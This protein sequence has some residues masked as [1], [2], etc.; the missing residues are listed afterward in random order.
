MSRFTMI[1]P[2][3]F[4]ILAFAA[5]AQQP[6]PPLAH[7]FGFLE[8][9]IYK[10]DQRVQNCLIADVNGDGLKDVIIVNN[11]KNRLD[12]LQQRKDGKAEQEPPSD[13]NEIMSS[14]RMLHRKI[15]I[16]R[17]VAGLAVRDV[18]GDG[19]PDLIYLSSEPSSVNV[20][21]QDADGNFGDRRSV[22]IDDI[23]A[24][25]WTMDVGDV[26]GDGRPDIVFLSK[27]TMFVVGVNPNGGLGEPKRYKISGADPGLLRVLDVDEDGRQDVAFITQDPQFPVRL[28]L[29]SK[30][31]RLGPEH[32][33]ELERPRSV[34][35]GKIDPSRTGSNMLTVSDLTGRL[36]VHRLSEAKPKPGVPSMRFL[37]FPFE[38][39]GTAPNT[40]L[41]VAD[42]DG[43]GKLDVVVTD[44]GGA[45]VVLY[46]QTEIEGLDLGTPYPTPLGTSVARTIE[47]GGKNR[48]VT[49]SASEKSISLSAWDQNRLSFPRSLPTKDEPVAVEVVGT[50]DKARVV[51]VARVENQATFT[52]KFMLRALKPTVNGDAITWMPANVAGDKS[53]IDLN[54]TTRPADL[55]AVDADGDGND[56]LLVFSDDAPSL[57]LGAANGSFA[58]TPKSAQGSLGNLGPAAVYYGKLDGDKPA[59]LVSQGNFVRKMKYEPE[60]RWR[61]VD[62]FNAPSATAKVAGAGGFDADGDGKVELV[63]YDRSGQSLEFMAQ[64]DG[65][66]ERSFQ[67][68]VGAFT[69][70]GVHV[71]D[72][73]GDGKADLL[74]FDNDKMGVAFTGLNDLSM[75]T[76]ASYETPN[77]RARLADS[78]VGDLNGD[79]RVDVLT[80][81][82]QMHTL[83]VL[84]VQSGL[85]LKRAVAWPV[86]EEKT[87]RQSSGRSIEPREIVIGDVNNDNRSDIVT[88]VHDRVV[89]Y[90]QDPGE[91]AKPPVGI[92]EKKSAP[93][94]QPEMRRTNPTSGT[95]RIVDAGG[96]FKAESVEAA[97]KAIQEIKSSTNRDVVIETFAAIPDA[98]RV[99]FNQL[100]RDGQTK[101]VA[102]WANKRAKDLNVKGVYLLACRKPGKFYVTS[103]GQG[104]TQETV[105]RVRKRVEDAFR[106]GKFDDGLAGVIEIIQSDLRNQRGSAN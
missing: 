16:Q 74:M 102:D 6:D 31:G 100:D 45:R 46:R 43:D 91:G 40:D 66:W 50:G 54:L 85:K 70:K 75:E 19:K 92:A 82:A 64:K 4:L 101:F 51:Y 15:P 42:F 57:W 29:Q 105:Q 11:L 58:S 32:Q 96:F 84:A 23:V 99:R 24:R 18:N 26:D 63:M 62:Q 48:L 2:A 86:F 47:L 94:K 25:E 88:V 41:A 35:W 12:L 56:D 61:V 10:L 13:T 39:T 27:D 98:E 59:L 9:E 69:L 33:I 8:A 30:Q 21:L 44:A 73:N 79:G 34:S 67:R 104:V 71:G 93:V 65:R 5:A 55:R 37:T 52:E 87:F 81:D 90:L 89:I 38:R 22:E 20:E 80:M 49:L 1:A 60:G 17:P 95:P 83:E 103:A 97:T 3:A 78:A 77:T 14:G 106:Q 28:R 53:E 68:K 76:I 72:F 7:Y 36:V